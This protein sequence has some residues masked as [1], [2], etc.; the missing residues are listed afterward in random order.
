M[1]DR[2]EV[3]SGGAAA[4]KRRREA[5]AV[6]GSKPPKA[7]RVEEE[8]AMEEPP[9]AAK[10]K[11]SGGRGVVARSGAVSAAACDD[12]KCVPA[13][14]KPA[15]PAKPAA[16]VE[17]VAAKAPAGRPPKAAKAGAGGRSPSPPRPAPRSRPAAPPVTAVVEEAV[18]EEEEDGGVSDATSVT[19]AEGE[20]SLGDEDSDAERLTDASYESDDLVEKASDDEADINVLHNKAVLEMTDDE[21]EARWDKKFAAY[22]KRNKPPTPKKGEVPIGLGNYHN[23]LHILEMEHEQEAIAVAK[24]REK[25]KKAAERAAKKAAEGGKGVGGKGR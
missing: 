8:E 23:G 10:S 16:A 14:V 11:L 24:Y 2:D 3:L 1:A 15:K 22:D 21:F 13:A 6:G 9:A 20:G 7:R 12:D 17:E 25:M 18:E 19:D 5:D 4:R